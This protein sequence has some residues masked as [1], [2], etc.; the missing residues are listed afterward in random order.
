MAAKPPS[1]DDPRILAQIRLAYGAAAE[2]CKL[3]HLENLES[4]QEIAVV[5]RPASLDT[6][7]HRALLDAAQ[8][9]PV[10]QTLPSAPTG[11]DRLE[12]RERSDNGAP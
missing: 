5:E 10:G 12:I 11:R 9:W 8:N 2:A 6:E 3:K 7:K 1:C 4:P